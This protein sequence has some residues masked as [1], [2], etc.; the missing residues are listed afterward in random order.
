MCVCVWVCVLVHRWLFESISHIAF[1]NMYI[2]LYNRQLCVYVDAHAVYCTLAEILDAE[3]NLTF[4][5]LVVQVLNQILFTSTELY[6][7]RLQLQLL[8]TPVGVVCG[9]R[10]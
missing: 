4:A 1:F 8:E 10:E 6:G 9:R 2:Y 7:L 3:K 5:C